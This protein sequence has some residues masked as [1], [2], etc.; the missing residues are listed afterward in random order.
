[1]TGKQRTVP[2]SEVVVPDRG[3]A[4]PEHDGAGRHV[5][6][7]RGVRGEGS[8]MTATKVIHVRDMR[9]YPKSPERTRNLLYWRGQN[10]VVGA[11]LETPADLTQ[12]VSAPMSHQSIPTQ[13]EETTEDA[14][15]YGHCHC[16]C[17]QRTSIIKRSD[18]SR[19]LVKGEP[20]KFVS[21]H[22]RWPDTDLPVLTVSGGVVSI[23]LQSR[24]YSGLVALVDEA[25][26]ELI[27]H[28]RW[29][30]HHH[31]SGTF[32]AYA[33][34]RRS[35]GRRERFWLHRLIL[36]ITD[37]SVQVDHKNHNGLD[38]QR[39]NLRTANTQQNQFNQR[40]A[41]GS[42]SRFRGVSW[43]TDRGKWHAQI[44]HNNQLHHLGRFDIEEDAARAYD[45]AAR[46]LFGE[47]AF[48]NLSKG[49]DA[50]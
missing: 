30:P 40:S 21:S 34:T 31:R 46:R 24:K 48:Q 41:K 6:R 3:R 5:R 12:E 14:T 9:D 44:R 16:G 17:G 49:E 47:F 20:S 28:L 33:Y 19:G 42:T 50:A 32:Y 25:D 13:I 22:H 38:N 1:M 39:S 27:R 8:A 4:Q 43:T 11:V 7:D 18:A 10:R 29:N 37:P 36:G 35:G 26:I 23:P 2:R 15:P 45:A